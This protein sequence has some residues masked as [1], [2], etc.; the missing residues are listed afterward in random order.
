[1]QAL[2]SEL[3][4]TVYRH[5]LIRALNDMRHLDQSALSKM[6]HKKEVFAVNSIVWFNVSD[7]TSTPQLFKLRYYDPLFVQNGVMMTSMAPQFRELARQRNICEPYICH[8]SYICPK[9]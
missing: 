4:I 2:P 6:L 5:W 7:Y 9:K 3:S 1:M 8:L